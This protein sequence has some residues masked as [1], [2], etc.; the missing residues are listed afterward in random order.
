MCLSTGD[1]GGRSQKSVK[2]QEASLH[3]ASCQVRRKI[4]RNWRKVRDDDDDAEWRIPVELSIP[5]SLS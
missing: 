3:T 5:V 1:G 2:L 4:I